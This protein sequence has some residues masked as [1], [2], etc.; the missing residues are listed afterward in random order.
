MDRIELDDR[1]RQIIAL[2]E[3]K[4]DISQTEIAEHVGLSQPT[5]GAR[6]NK[7][8]ATG[9]IASSVGMDLKKAGLNVAKV[10][11]TTRDSNEIIDRLKSCPYFLN[12]V[13]VSGRENLCL[14]LI[15]EDISTIEALVD[16]HL[17]SNPSVSSVD[18]G[19]IISA[20]QSLA[21]PVKMGFEKLDKSPCGMDC[22]DCQYYNHNRC[23]GCPRTKYYKGTFW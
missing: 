6:I 5:V 13:I 21:M 2:F 16:R 15:A 1:D 12:G 23:L 7:L 17:R 8:R 11:V 18:F 10:D 19:I 9:A 20:V 14:F 22:S 3:Q 4:P